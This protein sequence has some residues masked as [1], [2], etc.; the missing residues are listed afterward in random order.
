MDI[1][2]TLISSILI[3]AAYSLSAQESGVWNPTSPVS[4]IELDSD[5]LQLSHGEWIKGELVSLRDDTLKFDSDEF[6][7]QSFDWEDVKELHTAGQVNVVFLNRNVVVSRISIIED[8]VVLHDSNELASRFEVTSVV[9][10]RSSWWALWEG[11]ISLGFNVRS[12]NTNQT[13]LVIRY[14][15]VNRT[16]FNRINID[17]LGNFSKVDKKLT[18]SNHNADFNW[19]YFFNRRFYIVPLYYEFY[20]NPFK[21]IAQ[22]HTP[23][24]GFGYEVLKIK[25]V[26]W[27]VTGG[28]GYRYIEYNSV[29]AGK[30]PDLQSLIIPLATS[31]IIDITESTG[32]DLKYR[33][34]FDILNIENINQDFSALINVDI[35][36]FLELEVSFT[37]SRVGNPEPRS[38]GSIPEKDDF[39]LSAGIGFNY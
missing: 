31:L 30:N 13:D 25:S 24:F 14:D 19:S 34:N 22:Q 27:E 18:T 7:E 15:T 6:D 33:I 11:R 20:N 35:T 36:K 29:E 1:R 23:A 4:G 38:D 39:G 37:W 3:I 5:W 8:T 17:Y 16:A 12:G 2:W 28:L 21:N 26:D 32:L 9:P 10:S